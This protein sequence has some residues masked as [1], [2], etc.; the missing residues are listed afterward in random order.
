MFGWKCDY[1]VSYRDEPFT[2]TPEGY[3]E[4]RRRERLAREEER[5]AACRNS[6]MNAEDR[7]ES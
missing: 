2:Y 1:E 5:N 6:I 4:A 7:R 3:F